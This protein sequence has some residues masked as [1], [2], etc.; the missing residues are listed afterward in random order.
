[1]I[2]EKAKSFF[3]LKKKHMIFGI[4]GKIFRYPNKVNCLR[5]VIGIFYSNLDGMDNDADK[6]KLNKY[7][8]G[9]QIDELSEEHEDLLDSYE[10]MEEEVEDDKKSKKSALK[11][12]NGK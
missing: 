6:D 8:D 3:L 10:N 11:K 2:E 1:L 4:N 5:V 12:K 7:K 9:N